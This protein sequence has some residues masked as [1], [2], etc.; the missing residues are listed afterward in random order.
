[1]NYSFVQTMLDRLFSSKTRVKLLTHFLKNPNKKFYVRE[2][3]RQIDER[4][5]SVRRELENL[6]ELGLLKDSRDDKKR[7]YQVD[8]TFVYYKE[9]KALF[10]KAM[11]M[12][13]TKLVDL[14]EKAGTAE[15]VVLSGKFTSSPS[16]VDIFMIGEFSKPKVLKIIEKLE[17]EQEEELTYTIMK[18]SEFTF[19]RE[20]G[21]RF[22]KRIFDHD[23]EVVIDKISEEVKEAKKPSTERLYF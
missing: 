17:K 5:N 2:L 18:K 22:L 21:D 9:L 23:Y 16:G 14:F 19:R 20:Y 6:L 11:T 3:T 8:K 7:Y 4:I 10:T 13:R 1:M 15:Y 12:P